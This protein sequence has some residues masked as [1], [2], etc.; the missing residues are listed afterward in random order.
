MTD[1]EKFISEN[2]VKKKD[3][4]SYLGVSN[5]FITQLVS[6]KRQL[7]SEKLALIKARTDWNTSMFNH[8]EFDKHSELAATNS[9]LW[10]VI[11]SQQR[12]IEI[13]ARTIA[14]YQKR[15]TSQDVQ[16]A[17]TA[18]CAAASGQ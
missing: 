16:A 3:I 13:Q 6:G 18:G 12:T 15:A 9:E 14:D 8:A 11:K 7:P 5:A 1:F 17:N 4:A 2:G 10:E